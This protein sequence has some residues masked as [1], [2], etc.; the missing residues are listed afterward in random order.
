MNS[1][2]IAQQYLERELDRN[3]SEVEEEIDQEEIAET[4]RELEEGR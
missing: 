1:I 4:Q 2:S 3:E